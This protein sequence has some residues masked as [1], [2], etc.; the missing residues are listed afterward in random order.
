MAQNEFDP[1][2]W[3]Q[4]ALDLTADWE[5]KPEVTYGTM[6]DGPL[7]TLDY[8]ITYKGR[9]EVGWHIVIKLFKSGGLRIDV[10][11]Q[12]SRYD[13][14]PKWVGKNMQ[15]FRDIFSDPKNLG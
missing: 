8:N 9:Y 2:N 11:E 12:T 10:K 3:V 7:V 15:K 1:K 13:K 5:G 4:Q 6:P 14:M